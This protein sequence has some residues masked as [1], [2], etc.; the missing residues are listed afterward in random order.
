MAVIDAEGPGGATAGGAVRYRLGTADDL[1][2]CTGVWR[3]GIEDYQSRLN[4]PSMPED[5]APL[6]RL[7]L[8]I[9]DEILNLLRFGRGVDN[10]PYKA[11]G[12]DYG[13]T[14]REA[15]LD[16]ALRRALPAWYEEAVSDAR[17]ATVGCPK[18]DLADLPE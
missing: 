18:L 11:T 13:Y 8:R 6:R 15:V 2:A 3:A 16:Q 14:S 17:V 9:P 10:R 12:F 4:Q 7:G 1:D 5:L